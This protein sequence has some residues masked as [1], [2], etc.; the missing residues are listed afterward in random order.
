MTVAKTLS[1]HV[2]MHKGFNFI[3]QTLCLLAQFHLRVCRSGCS[4]VSETLFT[5][6]GQSHLSMLSSLTFALTSNHTKTPHDNAT[7]HSILRIDERLGQPV[8]SP[9]AHTSGSLLSDGSNFDQHEV[10]KPL[11][12]TRDSFPRLQVRVELSVTHSSGRRLTAC[13]LAIR[14]Q[15]QWPLL[16]SHCK[17]LGDEQSA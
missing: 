13:I 14:S 12:W 2:A 8:F 6:Q 16:Q 15:L 9:V 17:S 5:S 1:K 7:S 3:V 11:G 4:V 10:K